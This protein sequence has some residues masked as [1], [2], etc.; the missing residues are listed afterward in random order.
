MLGTQ[1]G[2]VRQLNVGVLKD[3]RGILVREIAMEQLY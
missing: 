1:L 2:M 3:N